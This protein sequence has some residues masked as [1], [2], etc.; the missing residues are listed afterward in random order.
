MAEIQP[1]PINPDVAARAIKKLRSLDREGRK[2]RGVKF[3]RAGSSRD[4]KD[5]TA[6]SYRQYNVAIRKR[7]LSNPGDGGFH[8]GEFEALCAQC[9]AHNFAMTQTHLF[10]LLSLER[11]DR[12][13]FIERLF[14]KRLSSEQLT[15]AIRGYY[16]PRSRGRATAPG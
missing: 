7:K 10:H 15:L 8:Q 12:G 14:E 3:I 2:L 4:P 1:E 11:D 9:K 16:P 6:L 5:G 13:A